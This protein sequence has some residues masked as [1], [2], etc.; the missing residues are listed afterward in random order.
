MAL[1]SLSTPVVGA[2]STAVIG[3]LGDAALI[4]GIAVAAVLFD[5]LFATFNCLRGGTTGLT[6]QAMGSGDRAEEGCILLRAL[7]VAVAAGMVILALERPAG[8]LGFAT[9]GVSGRTEAAGLTYFHLRIWSAPFVLMNYAILG[10]VLGRAEAGIALALQG[11]LNGLNVALSLVF[12]LALGWGLKGAAWATVIAEGT[13]TIGG[14]ALAVARMRGSPWPRAADVFDL[15]RLRRMLA[16]NSD[17]MIRSFSLLFSFAFFTRQGAGLGA[18]VLAANAILM[19]VFLIGSYLLDGFATAAEQLAGRAVGAGFRPA[20]DRVVRLTTV[21]VLATAGIICGMFLLFGRAL[22]DLMT[23]APEVRA[24]ARRYLGWAALTPLAGC[25]AFQM[26]GI[27]IGATWSR[28]MRNMMLLSVAA[29]LAAAYPLTAWFGN[30][31]LWASLLIFLGARS[32]AF[33]WRMR[34]LLPL[35]FPA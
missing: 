13:T 7:L 34:R 24:M 18:V 35:T 2:V 4:G 10:W 3:Q 6:A 17:M 11:F 19:H 23:T 32:L 29:Y 15:D 33:R 12:V 9:M 1:A 25:L 20:F 31:G 16:I 5:I 28:D 21:W 26:D 22:V 27:F 8:V 14:I 30:D